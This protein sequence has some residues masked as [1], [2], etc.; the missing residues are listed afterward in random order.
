[1]VRGFFSIFGT[2]TKSQPPVEDDSPPTYTTTAAL[3]N[4]RKS[5]H[6]SSEEKPP[7]SKEET[8]A[9]KIKCLEQ[10]KARLKENDEED[11]WRTEEAGIEWREAMNNRRSKGTS[12]NYVLEDNAH[13]RYE[14]LILADD[15]K[16]LRLK[17]IE[18]D[19]KA[20]RRQD[21]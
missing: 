20:L 3:T 15:R 19:I 21:Q 8:V 12:A 17:R 1:M 14:S 2:K 5:S 11:A 7:Q 16:H 18:L 10:E 9:E 4:A 13:A 6:C